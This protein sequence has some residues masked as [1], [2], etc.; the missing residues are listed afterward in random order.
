[1][2]SKEK[3]LE[4]ID[5]LKNDERMSYPTANIRTNAPLAL[6]QLSMGSKISALEWVLGNS[7]N[8]IVG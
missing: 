7:K 6:I 3:I 8:L 5:E 2:I 4:K 1:M